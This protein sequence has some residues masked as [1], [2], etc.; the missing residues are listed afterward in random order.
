MRW[1]K[2]QLGK[3]SDAAK[4]AMASRNK[5][6]HSARSGTP[7]EMPAARRREWERMTS[8]PLRKTKLPYRNGTAA[9]CLFSM[10]KRLEPVFT[11]VYKCL[12]GKFCCILRK[13]YLPGD[14]PPA[15]F[16]LV[17]NKIMLEN[18]HIFLVKT[19]SYLKRKFRPGRENSAGAGFFVCFCVR[20]CWSLV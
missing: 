7:M 1:K 2:R 19:G 6:A 12:F 9:S 18:P 16:C 20:N 15:Y 8:A 13:K 17:C 14:S 3:R 10:L 4:S 5:N 11:S